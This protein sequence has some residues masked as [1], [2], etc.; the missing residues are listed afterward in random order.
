MI[1]A[2]GLDGRLSGLYP[3]YPCGRVER[4]K[5]LP[6]ADHWENQAV[7]TQNGEEKKIGADAA[8]GKYAKELSSLTSNLSKAVY[9]ENPYEQMRKSMDESFLAGQNIDCFA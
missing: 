5:K 9:G 4:V 3:Q 1:G 6:P 8:Y 2:V 7:F